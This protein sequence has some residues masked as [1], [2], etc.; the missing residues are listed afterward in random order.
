MSGNT[1]A[2]GRGTIDGATLHEAAVALAG[3]LAEAGVV[4]LALDGEQ[5]AA[6]QTDLPGRLAASPEA[7][8]VIGDATV[9]RLEEGRLV[10]TA[11]DSAI[12][13][14]LRAISVEGPPGSA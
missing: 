7:T 3:A 10:W 9:V 1:D 12:A 11:G 2:A 14:A 8:L 4:E 6:R 13:A 5:L